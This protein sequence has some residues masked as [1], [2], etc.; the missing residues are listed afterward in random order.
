MEYPVCFIENHEDGTIQVNKEALN[1]LS[2]FTQKVVVVSIVGKY[3]TG[4]SYLMNKLAGRKNGFSLGSTVQSMTKGIWMWCFPHPV[5][6]DHTLVLLDTEGLG[7]VEKG[8]SQ[9]DSWIFALAVLLSST[10]VFN[11]VGTIDQQAMDQLHYVTELTEKI[12]VKSCEKQSDL[13]DDSAEFKRFFPSFV[14]C[15]RDFNLLLTLNG[16]NITEDEYL[17]NALKLRPGKNA[18]IRNYNLPREC[19]L[20]Y[21]HSHKC[22]VFDR[23]ASKENLQNMDN[24]Q[25]SQ[26][27]PAFVQQTKRFCQYIYEA[28]PVKTLSGGYTMTGRGLGDVAVSYVE[29]IRSGSIPSMENAVVAL[30]KIENARAVQEALSKYDEMMR[31]HVNRFPTETHEEFLNMDKEVQAEALKV[32]LKLSFK[33]ENQEYQFKLL[34]ELAGKKAAYQQ[35]NEEASVRRCRTLLQELSAGMEKGIREGRFTVPGGYKL[36]IEDKKSLEAD[37]MR[38]RGKGLK[39]LEVLQEFLKEKENVESSILTADNTL[40]EQ[41]KKMAEQRLQAEAAARDKEILEKANMELQKNIENEHESYRMHIKML[42]KKMSEEREKMKEENEWLIKEKLK[43]QQ[44]MLA[45]GF[46][47]QCQML[48]E[49][50]KQLR[51]ENSRPQSLLG[52]IITAILPGALG[53]IVKKVL[54]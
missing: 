19:I 14:W 54:L 21:F 22:F 46:K 44:E 41:E 43:E 28:S 25:E 4:K 11:S 31:Q 23:P 40:K 5:K 1:I 7:D 10:L 12:K 52:E 18:A 42:E 13:E 36:L 20:H 30:A 15:V 49:E 24:V 35:I 37:Y 51:E 47:Q 2:H 6:Q 45:G 53:K 50:I 27:D 29:S 38:A 32:F 9:N 48:E 8:N 33:D 26:L 39:S 16:K 17:K 3:R 34:E